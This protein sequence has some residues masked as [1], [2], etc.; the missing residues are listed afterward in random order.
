[1]MCCMESLHS[2]ELH[3][4]IDIAPFCGATNLPFEE[5]KAGFGHYF[6][7]VRSLTQKRN[8]RKVLLRTRLFF[9]CPLAMVS[10]SYQPTEVDKQNYQLRFK[11]FGGWAGVATVL[12][13]LISNL[14]MYEAEQT[15]DEDSWY[16]LKLDLVPRADTYDIEANLRQIEE[17]EERMARWNDRLAEPNDGV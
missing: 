3:R 1:M 14:A 6:R 11:S 4:H 12:D 5:T 8:D 16:G 10:R 13:G 15:E 2:I 9:H 17:F 7:K